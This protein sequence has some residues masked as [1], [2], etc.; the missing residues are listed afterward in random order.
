MRSL[1]I[2]VALALSL[3]SPGTVSGGQALCQAFFDEQEF[4]SYNQSH[5]KFKKGLET[6]EEGVVVPG[7]K[8]C[9]PAPLGPVPSSYFP[10]GLQERN[11]IIQDNIT[12]GPNPAAPNPSGNPCA[13]FLI[14]AGFAG[15]NSNKVG[16][17]LFL[18]GIPASLDLIF[19]EPNHT[20][21][22]F[23]LSRFEGFPT[24]GWHIT[25][26]N[27]ADEP[28]GKFD[29]A[30]PTANEP[31]KGFFGV[32]CDQTLGRINI[33]DQAGVTPDAIDDIWMWEEEPTPVHVTT[34]GGVKLIYR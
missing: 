20:G 27:K 8:N 7:G 18:K 9:F 29:V 4:L 15:S 19:T 6:F 26:Y 1:P 34:W 14:G 30:G 23:R 31:F 32:W 17:D 33:Y 2:M 24:G 22:G 28:I 5:G 12:T 16:E 3:L 21:V 13:L 10:N 11:L 25:I